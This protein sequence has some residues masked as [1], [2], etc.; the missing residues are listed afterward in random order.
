MFQEEAQ[1]ILKPPTPKPVTAVQNDVEEENDTCDIQP[2]HPL[3]SVSFEAET[4]KN[5]DLAI[6][7]WHDIPE[8]Q[9]GELANIT[10]EENILDLIQTA[11][12]TFCTAVQVFILFASCPILKYFSVF[13]LVIFCIYLIIKAL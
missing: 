1:K 13:L 6:Q 10:K 4:F 9:W 7:L 5:L 2:T 12:E 11:A 3:V 8:N